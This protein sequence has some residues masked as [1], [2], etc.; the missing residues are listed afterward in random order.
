MPGYQS[1]ES[2]SIDARLRDRMF[3]LVCNM[4]KFTQRVPDF[5]SLEILNHVIKAFFV[6]QSYQVDNWIHVPTLSAADSHP[7]FL[8]AL[9]TAGS[10]V[11]SVPAI[12]K[13]GL[14]LQDVV[15]V[16]IGDLVGRLKPGILTVH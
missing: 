6:K 15:R 12:W 9:V 13:M 8:L 16:T 11:I 2:P 7:E 4:N 3:Y 1:Y 5:P 14:V 10:T